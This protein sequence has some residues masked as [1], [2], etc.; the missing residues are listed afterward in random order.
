MREGET[1]HEA[2]SE[3]L[4]PHTDCDYDDVEQEDENLFIIIPFAEDP[5]S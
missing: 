2:T 1:S 3:Q 5:G 4:L